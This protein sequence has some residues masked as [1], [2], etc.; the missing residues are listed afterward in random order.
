MLTI[1]KQTF[2]MLITKH[3]F[4]PFAPERS[5]YGPP[6]PNIGVLYV[7]FHYYFMRYRSRGESFNKG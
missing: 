3:I 4:N 2:N 6:Q 1:T 5:I 7:V